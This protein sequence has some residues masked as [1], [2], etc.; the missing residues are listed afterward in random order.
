MVSEA[1]ESGFRVL[2]VY[3]SEEIGEETM[4]RISSLVT[5]PGVLAVIE[6]R[7]L[8]VPTD[9]SGGLYLALDGI[10]DP[11]NLGTILRIADWFGVDG[12]FASEDCVDLYN[13]K[14]LQASMGSV[15]RVPFWI[16]DLRAL[17]ESFRGAGRK[18]FG[19]LLDGEDIYKSGLE[20]SGLIVMGSESHGIS[21][22]V[23]AEV[24]KRLLIPRFRNPGA[25]SLNVAVATAV[26]LSEFRRR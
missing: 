17:C 6:K 1:L 14:T 10:R 16:A 13:P 9:F 15:F 5:P 21:E 20:S 24:S 25:E 2:S 18:I 12:V 22:G 8:P 11:G 19:T 3:R 4:A 26:I 23:R 7:L